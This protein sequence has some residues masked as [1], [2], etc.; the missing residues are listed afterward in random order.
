MTKRS[1]FGILLI[2]SVVF[3]LLGELFYKYFKVAPYNN[4]EFEQELAAEDTNTFIL[5]ADSSFIKKEFRSSIKNVQVTNSRNRNSIEFLTILD[6]YHMIKFV[7]S[8][9]ATNSQ[10][11]SMTYQKKW[12]FADV[13]SS[14]RIVSRRY[15]DFKDRIGKSNVPGQ[16]HLYF[17]GDSM[18][19][20]RLNDSTTTISLLC[21]D[22]SLRTASNAPSEIRIE[23]KSR[24]L[25][26]PH[27][28]PIEL[29][30]LVRSGRMLGFAVI[31]IQKEQG[32]PIKIT[33]KLI[34]WN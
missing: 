31:P 8:D 9:S 1:I 23:G 30:F 3:L 34:D 2:A 11:Y 20:D 4:E 6:T 13:G 27:K 26:S 18:Q 25:L 16:L 10:L 17:E 15:F 14:Y 24:V 21:E 33:A 32:I 7:L 5:R 19:V 12:Q 28:V 22:L 29:M